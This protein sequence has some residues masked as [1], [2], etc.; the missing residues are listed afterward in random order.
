MQLQSLAFWNIR[1]KQRKSIPYIPVLLSSLMSSKVFPS[2]LSYSKIF[3]IK[4][5]LFLSNIPIYFLLSKHRFN[6]VLHSLRNIQWL[7]LQQLFPYNKEIKQIST[8]II[9]R[10]L[11]TKVNQSILACFLI[12]L[13]NKNFFN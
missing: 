6:V 2:T 8:I 12:I 11:I 3:K 13:K 7:I 1:T 9:N 5:S 4:P 10:F